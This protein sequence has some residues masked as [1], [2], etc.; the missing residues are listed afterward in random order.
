MT[1]KVFSIE[2]VKKDNYYDII[3]S[4]KKMISRYSNIEDIPLF[5]KQIAM[6][7]NIS[8]RDA[9]KSYTDIF[10]KRMGK[11]NIVLDPLGKEIDSFV[12]SRL[13][14]DKSE[15]SFFIGGAYGFEKEFVKKN[16][17]V[18]SL[19]RLT[20]SHKI[21]KIVLYEQIYRAFSIMNNHPYHK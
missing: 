4:Y 20:M 16:D 14:E 3:S 1:I 19:S 21:A 18:I 9:Q 17:L 6:S 5:N 8:Q 13:F 7:Q 11:Y 2:K 10:L 12:F 15:I